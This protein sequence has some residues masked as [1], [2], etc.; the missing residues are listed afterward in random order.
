MAEMR[1]HRDADLSPPEIESIVR[2]VDAVWPA[3]DVTLADRLRKFTSWVE[4]N[5]R[6]GFDV[7]SF[8]VWD[9]S[10]AIAHART[11]ERVIHSPS[12]SLTVMGLA[13]V[14]VLPERRGEGLGRDVVKKAFRRIE[15]GDFAVSLFQTAVPDFYRKLGARSVTNRFVN[16]RNTGDPDATPWWDPDIMIYPAGFAWP[17]GTIDLNGTGY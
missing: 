14:C 13:G 6:T 17:E 4:D 12:S 2:L 7:M 5:R 16:S 9:G 15:A 8:V 11:F 10:Q 3:E 1:T